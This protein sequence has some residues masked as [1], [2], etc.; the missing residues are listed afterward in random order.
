MADIIKLDLQY[1]TIDTKELEEYAEVFS[2]ENISLFAKEQPPHFYN[3]ITDLIE[4]NLIILSLPLIS[5]I[6]SNLVSDAIYNSLKKLITVLN[7]R[8]KNLKKMTAGGKIE[9]G[10]N[11]KVILKVDNPNGKSLYFEMNN[12]P[13]DKLDDAFKLMED[14]MQNFPNENKKIILYNKEKNKWE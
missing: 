3:S 6:I 7:E 13:N 5:D 14:A 4:P 11:R 9:E 2:H 8:S 12:I 1:K 10:F